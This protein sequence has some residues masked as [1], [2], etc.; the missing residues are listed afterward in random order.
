MEQTKSE[1][2][3]ESLEARIKDLELKLERQPDPDKFTLVV[4]SGDLDRLLAAFNIATTAGALGKEVTM[5]FTFWGTPTLRKRGVKTAG[6]SFV[7]KA[8][9]WMLPGDLKAAPLS[10]MEMM[11]AGRWLMTREMQRKNVS[12][13]G[14]MLELAKEIGVQLYICEMTMSL[15]G[16]REEELIDYPNKRI[17]GATTFLEV[18]SDSTTTLFI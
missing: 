2:T 18:A 16:I 8:F 9:G 6:K 10:K 12:G 5:F 11:G 7:E 3:L 14:D 13:L 1:T 4:F 17:C 15:M